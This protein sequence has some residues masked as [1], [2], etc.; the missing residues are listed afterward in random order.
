[1]LYIVFLALA[2]VVVAAAIAVP[3]LR[4]HSV[5]DEVDRFHAARSITTTWSS[6]SPPEFKVPAEGETLED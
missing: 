2:L 6:E 3:L 4:R 5:L 1:M